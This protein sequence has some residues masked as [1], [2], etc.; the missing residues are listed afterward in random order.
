MRFASNEVVRGRCLKYC[1]ITM[2]FAQKHQGCAISQAKW[3]K[4]GS[5]SGSLKVQIRA[6]GRAGDLGGPSTYRGGEGGAEF[7]IK[8]K[9][10]CLQKS[11]LSLLMG[12]G[13]GQA[14]R[15][16]GGGGEQASLDP[17]STL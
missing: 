15:L 10:C 4:I 7:E 8:H 14:S 16:G 2:V 1:R 17:G 13:G 5:A 12:V 9:S 3:I 11:R 6:G